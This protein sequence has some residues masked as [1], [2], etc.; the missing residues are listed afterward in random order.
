MAVTYDPI[1]TTTLGANA[2][3]ITF[4]SI[5]NT[6]TDLRVVIVPKSTGASDYNLFYQFNGDTAINYSYTYMYGT[7]TATNSGNAGVSK[8]NLIGGVGFK[9]T[10][11]LYIAD[12]FSY[13]GSTYKTILSSQSADYNGSGSTTV[14]VSLWRSTSAINQIV[15]STDAGNQ[16][17]TG[18]TVTIYGI[19]AA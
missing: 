13:T 17:A 1:A 9:T 18:T 5:P 11:S 14:A 16:F 15:F 12:I 8:L 3:T 7:G 6:Y 19:K 4:S 10:P 2:S